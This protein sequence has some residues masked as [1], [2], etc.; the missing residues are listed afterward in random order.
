M[1]ESD[2][3]SKII[4]LLTDGVNNRGHIAPKTIAEIAKDMGIKVYTIGVGRNGTAPYPVFDERGRVVDVVNGKVEIDEALLEDIAE[5]TGGDYFRATDKRTL[6]SIYAQINEMEK[7]KV[8][9]YETV[10]INEE[11]LRFLLIALALI[12]SEFLVK[13]IILKRIP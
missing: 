8:E 5:I 3:K 1:R 4:I 11:F 12:L 6:E 10:H 7:S 13:Y 9:V 2:S